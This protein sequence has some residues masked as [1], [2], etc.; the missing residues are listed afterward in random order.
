MRISGV[1]ETSRRDDADAQVLEDVAGVDALLEAKAG[2]PTD[3]PGIVL[4]IVPLVRAGRNEQM[5]HPVVVQRP[6]DRGVGWRPKSTEKEQHLVLL[7]QPAHLFD[8]LRRTVAVVAADEADLA[9][10]DP[11]LLIAK[12]AASDL[13]MTPKAEAE[14]L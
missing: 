2:K 7:D 8:S 5:R 3:C 4:G 9:S 6:L 14:P 13:P 12:Y 11:A 1:F 10:V